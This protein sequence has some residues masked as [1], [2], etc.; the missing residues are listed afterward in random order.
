[1]FYFIF[2]GNETGSVSSSSKNARNPSSAQSK[3]SLKPVGHEG[4]PHQLKASFRKCRII[5]L[6]KDLF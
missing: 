5:A 2:L 6:D 3:S 4:M 1:M